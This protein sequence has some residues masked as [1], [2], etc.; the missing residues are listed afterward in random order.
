MTTDSA[1]IK[2]I[3]REYHEQLYTNKFDNLDKN[4]I[5]FSYLKEIDDLNGLTFDKE[6]T[7]CFKV[8]GMHL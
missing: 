7:S 1:K 8:K 2:T 3:P 4:T 6:T 5:S